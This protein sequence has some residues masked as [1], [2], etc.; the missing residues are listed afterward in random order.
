MTKSYSLDL[1]ERIARYVDNGGSRHAA[2]AQLDVSVSFVVKLMAAF[3]QTGR[4]AAKPEGGW[5]YSKLDP[6]R[7]FLMGRVT[8]KDDITMSEL[9]AELAERGTVVDPSSLSRW[10]IR[11]GYRF[12][13]NIAGQRARSTRRGS[14]TPSMDGQSAKNAA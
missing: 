6:H 1:R 9:A 12:K 4:L 2:A 5:R 13:K 14:R 3:R 8:E 11:N 7:D 10:L